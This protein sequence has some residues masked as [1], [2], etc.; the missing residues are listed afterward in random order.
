MYTSTI[1]AWLHMKPLKPMI[2]PAAK[3]A[4]THSH[5]RFSAAKSFN[6]SMPSSTSRLPRETIIAINPQA[7][8]AAKA[9][10]TATRQ[11][12]LEKGRIFVNTHEYS[13]HTGYPGGCGTPAYIEPTASSPESSSVTSGASVYR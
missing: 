8:A 5:W 6:P 13:V 4:E 1:T 9:E 2:R 3:P 12:M 7:S 11:A 10:L